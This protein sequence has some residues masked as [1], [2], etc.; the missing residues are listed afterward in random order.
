MKALEFES[1]MKPGGQIVMPANLAEEIPP[2]EPLRVVVMWEPS[3]AEQAW[4]SAAKER[5]AA[6]YCPE[7]DVYEQLA[8]DAQLR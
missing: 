7:D 6:A 1:T 3:S 8:D 2:G 5:F 4:L